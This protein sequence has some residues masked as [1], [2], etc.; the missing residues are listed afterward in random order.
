MM[1][2]ADFKKLPSETQDR[3]LAIQAGANGSYVFLDKVSLIN[4]LPAGFVVGWLIYGYS[5][6]QNVQWQPWM[7]WLIFAVSVIAFPLALLGLVRFISPKVSKIKSGH[8]VTPNEYLKVK[9][10][11]VQFIGLKNIEA[12]RLLEDDKQIEIWSGSHEERI[13]VQDVDLAAKLDGEFDSLKESAVDELGPILSDRKYAYSKGLSGALMLVGVIIA[14]LVGGGVA[15]GLNS[16]NLRYSENVA[17]QQAK[18]AGTI[19]SIEAFKA[20][21]PNGYFTAEADRSIGSIIAKVKENYTA[22]VKK[23]ANPESVTAF[24]AFLDAI[25]KQP[26]R[27]VFIKINEVREVDAGLVATLEDQFGITVSSYESSVP[28]ASQPRKDKVFSDLKLLLSSATERGFVNAELVDELPQ[29][30]P[31]IEM[32]L[33]IKPV[34]S[35]YRMTNFEGGRYYTNNHPVASFLFDMTLNNG[36]SA[37]PFKMQYFGQA[38]QINTGLYDTRDRDNFSFDKMLFLTVMNGFDKHFETTFGLAENSVP[39]VQ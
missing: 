9:G 12:L 39:T 4:L 32:T 8:M 24:A 6:S 11:Q 5:T 10:R 7:F 31:S 28:V 29:G 3:L 19:E 13:D 17:W 22:K 21:F 37:A 23:G 34:R 30:V 33:T 1:T 15:V 25:A 26:D 2:N 14:A 18:T 16:L 36:D 35:V 20:Q 38:T 27:K